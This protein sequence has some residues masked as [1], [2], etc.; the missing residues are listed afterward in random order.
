MDYELTD[1]R[2]RLVT[3]GRLNTAETRIDLEAVAPGVYFLRVLDADS[4]NWLVKK[5]VRQ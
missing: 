5:V 3:S 2:G 4:G 1:L